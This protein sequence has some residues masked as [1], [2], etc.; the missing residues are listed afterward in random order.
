MQSHLGGEFGGVD[1]VGVH[2]H[3]LEHSLTLPIVA[4]AMRWSAC[5]LVSVVH[6][7]AS[8][9]TLPRCYLEDIIH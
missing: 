2:A 4:H 7:R 5:R 6:P 9:V 1:R 3:Q 8:L